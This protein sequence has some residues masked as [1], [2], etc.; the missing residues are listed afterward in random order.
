MKNI[1]LLLLIGICS[2]TG[3]ITLNAQ[4]VVNANEQQKRIMVKKVVLA[5][6]VQ[7]YADNSQGCALFVQKASVKEITQDEFSMLTGETPKYIGYTTFP[8]VTLFNNSV[9]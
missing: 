7:I 3:L 9:K 6:G 1:F 8:Q 5:N 2:L 4:T